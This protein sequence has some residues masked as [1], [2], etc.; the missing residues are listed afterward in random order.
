[1]NPTPN[2]IILGKIN[3]IWDFGNF[4][5]TSENKAIWCGDILKKKTRTI[6]GA[7]EALDAFVYGTQ[8]MSR[9]NEYFAGQEQFPKPRIL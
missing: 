7:V 5:Q 9:C 4:F 8:A 3:A 6:Q 1:M 2:A